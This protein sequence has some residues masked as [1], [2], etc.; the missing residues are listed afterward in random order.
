MGRP[1]V[2]AADSARLDRLE[3]ALR[4]LAAGLAG[5]AAVALAVAFG[6]FVYDEIRIRREIR[7]LVAKYPGL[8]GGIRP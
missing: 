4:F 2:K 5:L 7:H 6:W 1:G 8:C 3:A